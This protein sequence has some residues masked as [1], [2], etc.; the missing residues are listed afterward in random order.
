MKK[1]W[2]MILGVVL[3]LSLV[4]TACSTA[5]TTETA[6]EQNEQSEPAETAEAPME[7]E[8][9]EAEGTDI[10]LYDYAG[11]PV[12]IFADGQPVYLKAWA[13]WCPSCLAGL[14]ELD[15]LFAEEH[16][17]K[18]VTIVAPGDFGEKS[19]DDFKEWLMEI[20]DEYPNVD[21]LFDR[22]ADM[23]YSLGIKAFPT[24]F[25]FD[26]NGEL[27]NTRVGHNDNA[28]IDSVFASME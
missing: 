19:E 3:S 2:I 18:V 25:Y 11:D 26:S 16:D 20:S 13:S 6:T 14:G 27:V 28:Y 17:Y 15:E 22:G 24:S 23:M 10:M 12:D 8:T 21:V 1:R 7:E 4:L 9:A 5:A